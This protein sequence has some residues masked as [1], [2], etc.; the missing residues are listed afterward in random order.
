MTTTTP[1]ASA[2]D[3]HARDE[4]LDQLVQKVE[5]LEQGNLKILED[6]ARLA[7]EI[8]KLRQAA[9]GPFPS[10]PDDPSTPPSQSTT[11][12]DAV[13]RR[14]L[15]KKAGGVVALGAAGAVVGGVSAPS[16]AAAD[17]GDAMIVGRANSARGAATGLRSLSFNNSRQVLRCWWDGEPIDFNTIPGVIVAHGG[18]GANLPDEE[19]PAIRGWGVNSNAV[20]GQS[21]NGS[22]SGAPRTR[23]PVSTALR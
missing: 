11:H 12:D 4:L 10:R 14:G 13:S 19:V 5:S 6:N 22:P 3:A 23:P 7:S 16:P 21:Q 9:S 17:A 18:K 1:G 20:L 15:L 8:D 2:G